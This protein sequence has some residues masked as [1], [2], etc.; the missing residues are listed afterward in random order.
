MFHPLPPLAACLASTEDAHC[1]CSWIDEAQVGAHQ[2]VGHHLSKY[3]RARQINRQQ[4]ASHAGRSRIITRVDLGQEVKSLGL[5]NGFRRSVFPINHLLELL[6]ILVVFDIRV[7]VCNL[8][9]Q[10]SLDCYDSN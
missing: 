1:Q 10:M 2:E 3:P 8:H 9:C 4:A 7:K 6:P 5:E